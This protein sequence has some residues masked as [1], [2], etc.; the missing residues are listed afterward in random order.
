LTLYYRLT[1]APVVGVSGGVWEVYGNLDGE[2]LNGG[3]SL[4]NVTFDASGA[5][6]AAT[7][8]N[9]GAILG[10]ADTNLSIAN[11]SEMSV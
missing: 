6:P 10:T 1:Q 7:N 3:A 2:A 11:S 5:Q 4:G 9:L 8:V